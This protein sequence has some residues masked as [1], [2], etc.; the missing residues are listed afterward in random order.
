MK[1]WA[2]LGLARYQLAVCKK[3]ETVLTVTCKDNLSD[4][5]QVLRV[6]R[7]SVSEMGLCHGKN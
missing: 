7:S 5:C 2:Y 1:L 6:S 3:K 4:C